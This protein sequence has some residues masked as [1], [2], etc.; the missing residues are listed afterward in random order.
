[1]TLA[2]VVFSSSTTASRL[3][4]LASLEGLRGV[5]LTQS[6]RAVSQN[7]CAYALRCPLDV[8]PALLALSDRYHVKHGHVYKELTDEVGRKMYRQ[9]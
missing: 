3:K 5:T 8:L 2:L 1:M 6:P 9:I 7:G 4:R